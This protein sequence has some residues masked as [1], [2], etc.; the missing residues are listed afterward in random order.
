MVKAGGRAWAA[1]VGWLA[2]DAV[3]VVE[4]AD[5]TDAD[6][7]AD[8]FVTVGGMLDVLRALYPDTAADGKQWFRVRFRVT[9]PS[10]VVAPTLYGH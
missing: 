2:V 9:E 5:L 8:G 4:L 3:D 10:R 7:V 1:G 6:A